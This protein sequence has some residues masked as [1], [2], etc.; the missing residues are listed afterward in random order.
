MSTD[1]YF[2]SNHDMEVLNRDIRFTEE[3]DE[4]AQKLNIVLQ[5]FLGEWFLN[6]NKGIPYTQTIFENG[7]QDI[8][9]LT[10]YFKS[11]VRQVEGVE[12][13]NKL[14]LNINRRGRTL[15]IDLRVNNSVELGVEIG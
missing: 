12:V 13:I 8:P 11:I 2:N 3:S 9:K 15:S 6:T 10:A 14:D 7:I 1:I 4:I 5:F